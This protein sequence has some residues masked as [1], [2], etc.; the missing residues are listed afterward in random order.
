M[1]DIIPSITSEDLIKIMQERRISELKSCEITFERQAKA[2]II[3][4]HGDMD[5]SDHIKV[6][7]SYLGMKSNISGGVNPEDMVI[8]TEDK[9]LAGLAKGRAILKTRREEVSVS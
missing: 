6:Q 2:T 7:A 9:R 5:A 8:S 4:Y 3:V 1:S